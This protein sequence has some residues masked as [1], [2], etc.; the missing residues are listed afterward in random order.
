MVSVSLHRWNVNFYVVFHFHLS[1]KSRLSILHLSFFLSML[2]DWLVDPFSIEPINRGFNSNF[3]IFVLREEFV[4]KELSGERIALAVIQSH[5]KEVAVSFIDHIM[6]ANQLDSFLL[7][8]Q[9]KRLVC[10]PSINQGK[11]DPDKAFKDEVK[12]RNLLVLIIDDS[13]I[14]CGCEVPRQE[15][16]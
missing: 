4:V 15:P 8:G 12:L 14:F 5:V 11:P 1:E 9:Y 7:F 3:K 2:V 10:V 16:E 6:V 13:I